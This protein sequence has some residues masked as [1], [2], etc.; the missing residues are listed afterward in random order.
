MHQFVPDIGLASARVGLTDF[1][2]H[3][4]R[5]FITDLVLHAVR[6]DVYH[7]DH[8]AVRVGTQLQRLARGVIGVIQQRRAGAAV[9]QFMKHRAGHGQQRE[10][11]GRRPVAD[12]DGLAVCCVAGDHAF[13]GGSACMENPRSMAVANGV[14]HVRVGAGQQA[15]QPGHRQAKQRDQDLQPTDDGQCLG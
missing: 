13:E 14:A 10:D 15:T 4:R 11:T 1:G 5:V 2:K 8:A 3:R 6:R 9:P 7:A 12:H